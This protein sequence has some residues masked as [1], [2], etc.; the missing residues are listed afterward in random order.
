MNKR[1]IAS[2]LLASM[3]V[4]LPVYA[5]RE[6]MPD[7]YNSD[8]RYE[9]PLSRPRPVIVN[10]YRT[11][12]ATD[13]SDLFAETAGN[14]HQGT[15][16]GKAD[17]A[18]KTDLTNAAAFPVSG[19]S[20]EQLPEERK[21]KLDAQAQSPAV[22]ER[23]QRAI[24]EAE[25][26]AETE[27][28]QTDDNFEPEL[29][30]TFPGFE[31]QARR[32][33]A[34]LPENK[35][36]LDE[37]S[38]NV[39][40][41]KNVSG[42]SE[43]KNTESTDTR[44]TAPFRRLLAEFSGEK[45][46][47][48]SGSLESGTAV[49][50]TNNGNTEIKTALSQNTILSDN[51][52]VVP[53]T[54][55]QNPNSKKFPLIITGE[56]A[57]Y[58]TESG[59]FIIEGNVKVTQGPSEMF[60][61]KAV[62]NEKTG[63]IW[64]LEGG[65]MKEPTNT[66]HAHW[67]HYNFN[68]ETGEL[69]H[70]KGAASKGGANDKKDY[71]EAPHGVI[72]NGML[73]IDQGG[74][75]TRCPAIRHSSCLSVKAKTITIIPN[76]RII[77]RG[78]Q[79]FA[80]GK[81]IYSRDVWINDFQESNNR[82]MPRAGW[83]DDKGFYVSLEYEQPI[84]NPLLKNPTK[85]SME[86]VY[87]TKSKY[88]P[89]YELRHDEHDFYVRLHHGY[90]YDSDND[91]IDEGIWLRKKMDWGF[92]LKP[93]RISPKLPLS[94]EGYI[95]QGRWKYTHR[96]WSSRHTEKVILLRHDRFYPLGGQKLYTDL[97]VGHKWV[98]E[99]YAANSRTKTYGKGLDSNILHATIGYRFSDKWN[100]WTAYHKEHKTS[101]NFSKG[102]P[103]FGEEWRNGISWSPD[104]H[105]RFSIVNR[106]NLDSDTRDSGLNAHGNYST[107][108]SWVHRFCCEVLSVSYRKKHYNNDNEWT[109]KFE[110]LNW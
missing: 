49:Q 91:D 52:A 78:V 6:G 19:Q 1:L 79:V 66:V 53:G 76:Q 61:T 45:S 108:F 51:S 7:E 18:R 92:F 38:Q 65:T 16:P 47:E 14:M 64:L 5:D 101:F 105:N 25:K 44:L 8:A 93:H 24:A 50:G 23:E 11:P 63:D 20:V 35:N 32:Q 67:A 10:D 102:Q 33:I 29:Q 43:K 27:L 94:Y 46:A 56:D 3:T 22:S 68:K 75:T 77:A 4:A 95:T 31:Y 109:V 60:S 86:Q 110:F 103:S 83:D 40:V 104:K 98:N 30:T 55:T 69:L 34:A 82:L 62:G 26:H 13:D 21:D 37:A 89:F 70:L 57:Q 41:N 74:M 80:K 73:V 96:D 59:D 81:H 107:T 106:R 99:S 2:V 15:V 28:E 87:Y 84:G 17:S 100:I 90:V 39:D 58:D 36:T 85:F 9:S 48:P 97:M 71:Y 42:S 72:E 54:E 88:K 12:K